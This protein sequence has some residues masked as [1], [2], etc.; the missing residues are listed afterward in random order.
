MRENKTVGK[1]IKSRN[2]EEGKILKWSGTSSKDLGIWGS[3]PRSWVLCTRSSSHLEF[4][5]S[6]HPSVLL[7]FSGVCFQS[8]EGGW[9]CRG[10]SCEQLSSSGRQITPHPLNRPLADK[11]RTYHRI[12]FILKVDQLGHICGVQNLK[13][14]HISAGMLPKSQSWI[15]ILDWSSLSSRLLQLSITFMIDLLG[16]WYLYWYLAWVLSIGIGYW[17]WVLG[18]ATIYTSLTSLL[19]SLLL[20]RLLGVDP[21]AHRLLIGVLHSKYTVKGWKEY[22]VKGW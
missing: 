5:T 9:L 4:I 17:Y 8:R 11:R 1:V 19:A 12:G 20:D 7:L 6:T 10:W 22:I 18:I 16:Y 3:E 14:I 2:G 21:P 15:K 13:T